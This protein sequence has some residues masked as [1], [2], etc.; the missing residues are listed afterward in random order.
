RTGSLNIAGVRLSVSPG[1]RVEGTTNDINAGTVAFTV[2]PATKGG[3]PQQGRADNI[4]LARPRFTLEPGGR[5]RA[6]AALNLG[7]GVLGTMNLGRARAGVVATNDQIQLSDFVADIFGGNARGSATI[8]TT[9]R[10]ASSVKASFENVDA[11]GLL[12][13]LSG[14]AVPLAG[15]AT[16]TVDL[17]FPGTNFRAASGRLDAQFNGATG[18]EETPRPPLVGELA[19][20]ADRGLFQIERANLR[21]GATELTAT[22]RFSFQ[23]GSDLA[24][25]INSTDAA[26]LQSVALSTGLLP[27]LEEKT[28]ELGI[29]LAGNLRFNGTITGDL[30]SPAVNGHF[31]LASLT[32]RGRDI[33]ALSAD[34]ASDAEA[35]HVNNGQLRQVGGGGITFT[36]VIPRAGENNISF[37]ATLNNADAGALVAA[38][39]AGGKTVSAESLA[40]LGPATGTISVSGFPGAMSGSAN[41]RVAAGRIGSQPY[42]E[43]VAQATF[44]GSNV[45]LDTFNMKLGAGRITATGGVEIAGANGRIGLDNVRV[46]DFRVQGTNVQLALLTSLFGAGASMPQLS[47]T[48][49]FTATLSG[50]ITSLN[51]EINAQ[52]RDVTINGQPAGQLTLVG[53]MT[54]DQKFVVDL[55]TGLLGQPQ[56]VHATVDL[57]GDNMPAAIETTLTGADL[58]PLFAAILN[59]PNVHVSG[60]ATGTLRASGNLIN[61]KDEF[62]T[63]AIEGRAEF[64]ELTVQV[65]DVPLTAENPFVVT[66]KP[67]E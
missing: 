50:S 29:Q 34:I 11:G 44:N 57:A 15:A 1:G 56:V 33:G 31:D 8:A 3:T 6:S 14:N 36:A 40:G 37:D 19:L 67:N 13:M 28:K 12:A 51:A 5:Y 61:D 18:R 52:G 39:G 27:S 4:R 24:V 20:T 45:H 7:G 54:P 66:F 46:N 47:G 65:E 10:A 38:L 53:H 21:A 59:N 25:N 41:V 17:R 64:T 26:E 9:A 48:S 43:I 42:D 58:T 22:A 2:P 35:T 49:D 30:D 60:H 62:T 16:G 55:T 32:A 23:G 63:E